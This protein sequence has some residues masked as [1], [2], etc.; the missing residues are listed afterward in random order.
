MFYLHSLIDKQN[1][2][3]ITTCKVYCSVVEINPHLFSLDLMAATGFQV[4][5]AMSRN[6]WVAHPMSAMLSSREL[7]GTQILYKTLVPPVS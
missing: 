3:R 1:E 4:Y 6:F 5:R 2:H 7:R